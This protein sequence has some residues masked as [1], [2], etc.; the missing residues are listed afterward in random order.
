MEMKMKS[1]QKVTTTVLL[2]KQKYKAVLALKAHLNYLLY[3]PPGYE[4]S[5]GNW[6]LILTLHGAAKRGSN[7]QILKEYGLPK[8]LEEKDIPFIVVAPQC[9]DSSWW[10][11]HLDEL[12]ALL[13]DIESRLRVDKSRI[14]L[15]G[16]SMGGEG[17]WRLAMR[18]PEKFAAIAPI[19]AIGNHGLT[20]RIKDIPAWVFHGAKDDIVPIKN[21]NDLV[22]ELESLGAEVKYTVYPDVGHE[23]WTRTYQNSELFL[24]FL[25]HAKSRKVKT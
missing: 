16:F 2:R 9:P 14:Y 22:K 20:H 25:C 10:T 12:K 3:L 24:W 8:L 5:K 15:T 7:I 23:A 13:D 17:T 1:P 19:C 6:P 4:Q 21:S 18:Y 11:E